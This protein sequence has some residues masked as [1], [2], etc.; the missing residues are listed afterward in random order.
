[1]ATNATHVSASASDG[2]R[3]HA[4]PTA[5][6]ELLRE[7]LAR[8]DVVLGGDRPWDIVVHQPRMAQRILAQGSLG[9]GES[10]MDGDW[11][12]AQLDE[13]LA[14]LM[15]SHLDSGL[16]SFRKYWTI[17][18]AWLRNPQSPTRSFT[19]GER[20]YDIGNDLYEQMLDRRMIYSCAYWKNALTLDEAQEHKLDLV[21]RKLGLERGMR[22]LDIG[23]GWGGAAL[24]AAERYGVEVTGITVSKEQAEL[25]RERCRG[26]PIEIVLDDYRSLEGRYDR[27][28][29]LGMFEHVGV[30]NYQTYMDKVAELL[31]P[32]GLFLLHTIGSNVSQRATDAWIDKYIFPNSMLPSA[33]QIAAA[34][35]PGWVIEDWHSFGVDYDRTL[36]AWS[37]N[38]DAAWPALSARYDQRFWR[39]WHF[40]LMSSAAAFRTR[41][42]QLWQYVLSRGGI[43]GGYVCVR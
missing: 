1:M 36:L 34:A 39:M 9:A 27:I 20:H 19:V 24:Y 22:V 35:E 30:A 37:R 13:M 7:L 12:C 28:Y 43:P 29:S 15:R 11:D 8:A 33:A 41:R 31:A 26:W 40:W 42:T 14:R 18:L 32:C 38:F 23:C 4:G 17:A 5:E 3:G 6:F 2:R 25:A 10:Y 21:C 16:R